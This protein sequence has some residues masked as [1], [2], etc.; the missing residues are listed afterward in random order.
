MLCEGDSQKQISQVEAFVAKTGQS[1]V[2]AF[3]PNLTADTPAIA[4][5]CEQAGVY[6]W[7]FAL[8]DPNIHVSD[9]KYW[10]AHGAFDF[11]TQGK[12]TG[13]ELIKAL[14]GSGNIV[15]IMGPRG[16]SAGNDRRAGLGFALQEAPGVKLLAQENV[17]DWDRTQALNIMQ[18]MLV[19]YPDLGGVWAANDELGLGALEALRSAG[20]AGIP[21][22]GIDAGD[23]SIDAILK[24]EFAATAS[25][26]MTRTGFYSLD[27]PWQAYLGKIDV[28]QLPPE[29]R[30][31][32]IAN[33]IVNKD[34]AQDYKD[35]FLN[36]VP[37]Y[38]I[39]DPWG[40]ST[41]RTLS[42]LPTYDPSMI[43]AP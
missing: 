42:D 22:V 4:Q 24:G 27:I 21:I 1:G 39:N 11:V 10:V 28:S 43:A 17:N 9:Y 31:F 6:C 3:D 12:L 34:N 20:K 40:W 23:E 30:E 35:H 8:K 2:L 7:S 36:G 13:Q 25:Q 18:N 37:D 5:V 29:H 33:R 41:G 19:A 38:D 14:G 32:E 16:H 15:A 26:E